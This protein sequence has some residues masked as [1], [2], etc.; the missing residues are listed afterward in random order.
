M[1]EGTRVVLRPITDEDWPTVESWGSRREGLWGSYQRFQLDHIPLLKQA[2]QKTGL[3]QRDSGLLMIETREIQQVIGFVRYTLIPYPDSDHPHPEIGFGIA[4]P[5]ARGQ[6]YAKE[7][8]RLLV[9]YLFA[10]YPSE[11]ISAFT[12]A[13]NIPA[14]RLMEKLGFQRE[15]SLRRS[16]FRDGDWQDTAL[17]GILRQ[18]WQAVLAN[19]L[20]E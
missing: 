18:E 19:H 12:D 17:Y 13:E 3:L 5:S 2:Y 15:G 20:S 11:R 7:A 4:E 6:G 9:D 8:V 1:I 14:Q 10:G 16:M